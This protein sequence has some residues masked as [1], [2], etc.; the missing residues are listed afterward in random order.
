MIQVSFPVFI[1]TAALESQPRR[2]RCKQGHNFN[3]D[4]PVSISVYGNSAVSVLLCPYCLIG[5][6]QECAATEEVV[7]VAAPVYSPPAVTAVG[8]VSAV[9]NPP[10]PFAEVLRRR[11]E[12]QG[13]KPP[14]AAVPSPVRQEETAEIE[15]GMASGTVDVEV[16]PVPPR[17]EPYTKEWKCKHHGR[18]GDLPTEQFCPP[19]WFVRAG[20]GAPYVKK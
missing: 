6:L 12:A 14:E 4:Q 10:L 2:Y 1:G 5:I 13:I 9:N 7:A 8:G 19:E 16:K 18:A 15:T 17:G 11:R 3:Q 20:N